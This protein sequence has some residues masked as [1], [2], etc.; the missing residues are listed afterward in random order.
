MVKK[1]VKKTYTRPSIK[2]KFER[3]DFAEKKARAEVK[4]KGFVD[5]MRNP[6][7]QAQFIANEYNLKLPES[8]PIKEKRLEIMA[9]ALDTI[10]FNADPELKERRDNWVANQLFEEP[11]DGKSPRKIQARP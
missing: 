5:A 8:N 2:Q 1:P 4:V 11:V 3:L 6:D 9:Q 10:D 7:L